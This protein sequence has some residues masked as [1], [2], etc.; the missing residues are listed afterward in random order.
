MS[1]VHENP[2]GR[3]TDRGYR[4]QRA[5]AMVDVEDLKAAIV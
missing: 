2:I 5:L 1:T 4:Q 3:S